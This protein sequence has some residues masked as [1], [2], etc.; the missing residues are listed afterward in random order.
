VIKDKFDLNKHTARLL[1]DEPFFAALSRRID[2]RET[3][4]LPTAGMRLD[5]DGFF[6]LLY[7]PD[8]FRGLTD[9]EMSDVL[10]HEFYHVI[11]EHVTGRLPGDGKTVTK[12]WNFATDL[13]INSHL[14][15]LPEGAL[16]P[17][18]GE[19]EEM[20]RGLSAEQYHEL[21]KKRQQ[22]E[23]SKGSAGEESSPS[24]PSLS[25][26]DD[27][28]DHTGWGEDQANAGDHQ[29]AQERLKQMMKDAAKEASSSGGWGSVP[30]SIQRDILQRI[31]GSLDWKKVLRFFIKTSQKAD[32]SSTVKRI[33][34]RY[35]YLHPGRKTNRQARVAVSIDQSGSVDDAMLSAFFGELNK[36]GELATFT[37]VPFDTAVSEEG[38][39]VWR[40]GD[41]LKAKRVLSG[42]TCFD[43]P[44]CWVNEREFDGHIILTDLCAPKPRPSRCQRMW[45]TTP[46]NAKNPYFETKERVVAI[47]YD[48][49]Y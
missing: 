15:H 1:M 30:Q 36:L 47:N 49:E 26:I 10:K 28:D 40:K 48:S 25:D 31:D 3:H 9:E 43:A 23:E 17:S 7:N 4:A 24:K 34:K 29:K 16:V 13:A 19:F 35:P 46:Y 32:K 39:F 45:L 8:Y 14:R 37:V 6:T 5:E 20:P 42:G 21:L 22:Q 11:F 12:L 18:E 44:T 41:K 33:N 38:V 27:F 2:K